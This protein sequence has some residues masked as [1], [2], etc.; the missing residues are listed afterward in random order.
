MTWGR[1][2]EF[3]SFYMDDNATPVAVSEVDWHNHMHCDF[4]AEHSTKNISDVVA[5]AATGSRD[6]TKV[7]PRSA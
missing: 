3:L 7:T 4:V 5:A 2:G 1:S 6:G